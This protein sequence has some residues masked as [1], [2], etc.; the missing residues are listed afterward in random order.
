V[1]LLWLSAHCQCTS[2]EHLMRSHV[3]WSFQYAVL[4]WHWKHHVQKGSHRIVGTQVAHTS[5]YYIHA[6]FS[7]RQHVQSSDLS[8]PHSIWCSLV[9][10]F[11]LKMFCF[12]H[13]FNMINI[14]LWSQ[15]VRHISPHTNY[16]EMGICSVYPILFVSWYLVPNL[17][18]FSGNF[19]VYTGTSHSYAL[20]CIRYV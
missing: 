18:T 1:W 14:W 5:S 20:L 12:L 9:S 19:C 6:P 3:S 16:G 17:L 11:F 2:S 10:F 15:K 7:Y 4:T 13:F 8:A